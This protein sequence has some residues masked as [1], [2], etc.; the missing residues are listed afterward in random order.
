MLFRQTFEGLSG[1]SLLDAYDVVCCRVCGMGFADGLPQ[2]EEF[3]RYYA[4]MSKYEHQPTGGRPS[5]PDEARCRSIAER[6]G[7]LIPDRRTPILDV[8]CSTGALLAAFKDAGFADVE[9]LDPAPAC[10]AFALEAYGVPVRTGSAADIPEFG[11]VYGV[12]LLSAVLEHLLD[13]RAVLY[14]V[15]LALQDGGC[16]F[17]EVPDVEAFAAGAT[18]PYQE[19]SIEHINFFSLESLTSLLGMA[20]FTRVDA[21]HVRLPWTSRMTAG[22]L[23]A[24][25]RRSDATSEWSADGVTRAALLA[26]VRASAR[27]EEAVRGRVAALADRGQPVLVWGVGTHTRHLLKAGVMDGLTIAAYVDSDPKC[28]GAQLR[29]VPVLA[30]GA[31]AGRDE[32][33]L[34][35]SGTLHHEI[36][37]QIREELG[38]AN[39]IVLLY[40]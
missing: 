24:V 37:R 5:A 14:D 39:E 18:V 29:G 32:P 17:V 34:V 38:A 11:T 22:V 10:A 16:L 7:A 21:E 13:P 28:Q 9:G 31:V 30:P 8:G 4:R 25:F 36:A 33:I 6:V 40:D 23:H 35:S 3:E 26:Y 20:G 12:V 1:R 27:I 15:R 2:P 19:F